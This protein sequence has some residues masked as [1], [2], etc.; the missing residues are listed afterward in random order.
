MMPPRSTSR[1][2]FSRHCEK[3]DAIFH[4]SGGTFQKHVAPSAFGARLSPRSIAPEMRIK[5]QR[6]D[7]FRQ[8]KIPDPCASQGRALAP[9]WIAEY[10]R[11]ALDISAQVCLTFFDDSEAKESDEKILKK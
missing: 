10:A 1:R 5:P 2:Y 4:E 7:K 8:P 9:N 11:R 6:Q 3:T